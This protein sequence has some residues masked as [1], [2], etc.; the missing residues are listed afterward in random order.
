[1]VGYARSCVTS[2]IGW[3]THIRYYPLPTLQD[4][5]C[6]GATTNRFSSRSHFLAISRGNRL[7]A[8]W[9]DKR[10]HTECLVRWS[11]ERYFFCS[12]GICDVFYMA[13]ASLIMDRPLSRFGLSG[14]SFISLILGFGC[15]VPAILSTRAIDD[16]VE[17]KIASMVIPL[18]PCN[19]RLPVLTVLGAALFGPRALGAVLFCYVLSV[20][21]SLLLAF[22]FRSVA[23][24]IGCHP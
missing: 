5:L 9:V 1:M 17:R 7:S 21:F 3:Y 8:L 18:I 20:L 4:N 15:N 14:K 22:A 12:F 23:F 24:N 13:R 6:C 2:P 16:P 19:A 11:G 10:L